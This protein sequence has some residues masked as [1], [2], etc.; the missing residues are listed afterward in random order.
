MGGGFGC[1]P[2]LGGGRALT[3]NHQ[4]GDGVQR[5]GTHGAGAGEERGERRKTRPNRL[6]LSWGLT[7]RRTSLRVESRGRK[8]RGREEKGEKEEGE[9]ERRRRE[10][11]PREGGGRGRE[12]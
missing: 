7:R 11:A 5:G 6:S 12:K 2:P 3:L 10:R 9:R 4:L 1:G 8:K